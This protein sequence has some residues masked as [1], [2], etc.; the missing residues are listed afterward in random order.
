MSH[1]KIQQLGRTTTFTWPRRPWAPDI[2]WWYLLVTLFCG[3]VLVG[4]VRLIGGLLLYGNLHLT[5]GTLLLIPIFFY[6]PKWIKSHAARFYQHCFERQK[7]EWD[8]IRLGSSVSPGGNQVELSSR[9][10]T[11]FYVT[12]SE[13]LRCIDLGGKHH[14]LAQ[15][16]VGLLLEL[17]RELEQRLRIED[18]PVEGAAWEMAGEPVERHDGVQRQQEGERLVLSVPMRLLS[19]SKLWFA[20]LWNSML[21]VPGLCTLSPGAV[22]GM[23]LLPHGWVGIAIAYAEW[24]DRRNSLRISA[25]R[26]LLR[27]SY[28]PWPSFWNPVHCKASDIQQLYVVQK[29][30]KSS[31]SKQVSYTYELEALLRDNSRLVL[32]PGV[33]SVALVRTLEKE[34][35]EFLGLE[36]RELPAEYR[37]E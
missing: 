11:Q 22:L 15:G 20:V 36:N 5:G 33:D 18:R 21:L 19:S 13:E 2:R 12:P 25:D 14:T 16:P 10:V 3:W 7:L 30:H 6:S 28:E 1:L 26:S 9:D 37:G 4:G 29:R 27:F 31:R 35:E 34:L 24:S 23:Y 17:E 32:L 8:G